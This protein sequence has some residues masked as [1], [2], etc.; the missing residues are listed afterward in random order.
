MNAAADFSLCGRTPRSCSRHADCARAQLGSANPQRQSFAW[1]A[2]T[3]ER[4][5]IFH[6]FATYR[7][8]A[9]M[10][11]GIADTLASG[12][13]VAP[14]KTPT[15]DSANDGTASPKTVRI[16]AGPSTGKRIA[17]SGEPG[18]ICDSARHMPKPAGE[19]LPVGVDNRPALG[20][21]SRRVTACG[22]PSSPKDCP[23]CNDALRLNAARIISGRAAE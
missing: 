18:V 8:L 6:D 19:N 11:G 10:G 1:P 16:S 23:N 4:C 5:P 17:G 9:N 14:G 21:D 3:G 15:T 13:I 20:V 7:K 12:E 22:G 2:D